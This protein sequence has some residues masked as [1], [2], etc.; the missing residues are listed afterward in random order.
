M[1]QGVQRID[2][3]KINKDL[4][5]HLSRHGQAGSVPTVTSLWI[6]EQHSYQPIGF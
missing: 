6:L 1:F 2:V 3:G 5:Y 4:M